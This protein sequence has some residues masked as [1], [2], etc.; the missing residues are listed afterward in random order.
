MRMIRMTQRA[1]RVLI[2]GLRGMLGG[3]L[4]LA[5]L[6]SGCS[7][8]DPPAGDAG[9]V[10]RDARTAADAAVGNPYNTVTAVTAFHDGK[11]LVMAGSNIPTHPQGADENMNLGTATQCLH[12]V[13]MKLNAGPQLVVT[14]ELGTL[15]GAPTA[16]SVGTCDRTTV[17]GAPLTFTTSALLI[18]NV[19][20]DGSCFDLRATYTGF[21]QEGR[22]AIAADGRSARYE[23][24]IAGVATGHRCADGPLGSKTVKLAGN[25]VTGDSVGT[26]VLQQ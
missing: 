6:L 2:G 4:A 20:A 1:L 26:F 5:L 11:T 19:A 23:L 25:P 17:F 15:N 13:T 14:T 24:Y 9:V 7:D 3:T 18:E 10:A 12:K 8:S 16:D 21:A 22:G